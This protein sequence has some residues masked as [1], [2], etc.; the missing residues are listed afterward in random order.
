MQ[1]A[2]EPRLISEDND[3]SA[4][5]LVMHHYV[6]LQPKDLPSKDTWQTAKKFSSHCC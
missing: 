1:H 4:K 3:L 2:Q 5:V 6:L